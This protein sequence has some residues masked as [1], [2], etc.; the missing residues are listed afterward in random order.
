MLLPLLNLT[1]AITPCI[2]IYFYFEKKKQLEKEYQDKLKLLENKASADPD[3]IEQVF[4][5]FKTKG[6]SIIRIDSNDIFYR[7][8]RG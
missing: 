4:S 6:F 5:D 2:A 8:P 1:L 3:T 7:S